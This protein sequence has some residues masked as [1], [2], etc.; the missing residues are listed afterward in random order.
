MGQELDLSATPDDIGIV[1]N[2]SHLSPTLEYDNQPRT[3]RVR[4]WSSFARL[5]VLTGARM[6]EG[7]DEAVTALH[8]HFLQSCAW[9][10]VQQRLGNRAIVVADRDWC[11]MCVVKR[12]G[13]LRYLY[14]PLGPACAAQKRST[15]RSPS[16]REPAGGVVAPKALQRW[17]NRWLHI[18]RKA[19]CTRSREL[20]SPALEATRG[21]SILTGT[22]LDPIRRATQKCGTSCR[23]VLPLAT[24]PARA[25][26]PGA[27]GP[28]P[29]ARGKGW[30]L[31]LIRR[32]NV[33]VV[34][35]D[36]DIHGTCHGRRQVVRPE[37][38]RTLLSA[39]SKRATLRGSAR[40]P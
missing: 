3:D 27:R 6:P 25:A 12:M 9:A 32:S 13:P 7:W 18:C 11:W 40:G 4:P 20:R 39:T 23:G 36:D 14:A 33:G 5:R 15:R 22:G 10:R 8:G 38:P 16:A 37:I 24:R 35:R 30:A 1:A 21:R 26:G 28:G 31:C 2:S 19:R 29:G 17:L 34:V